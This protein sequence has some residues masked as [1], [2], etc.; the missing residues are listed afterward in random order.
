MA[1]ELTVKLGDTFPPVEAILESST[2]SG[3]SPI[4]L[5]EAKKVLFLMKLGV[6]VI[7]GACT[8]PSPKTGNVIYKWK[9]GDTNTVGAYRL[10]WQIEWNSGGIESVPNE[11]YDSLEIQENL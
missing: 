8:Y 1:S 6:T 10:E 3:F 4:D 7:S 2:G 11:G 5:T 9:A